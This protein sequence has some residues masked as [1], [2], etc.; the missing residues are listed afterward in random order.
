MNINRGSDFAIRLLAHLAA[1]GKETTSAA[2]AKKVDV[3]LNHLAKLV[4]VLSRGGFVSTR[5]GKGGG[6]KL[7]RD[8]RK[9]NLAE[10]IEAVEGPMGL[11]DCLFDRKAC[12]FSGKC[13]VRKYLGKVRSTIYH[14]LSAKTIAD[15]I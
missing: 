9:I 8:P 3:P 1:E 11:S 2:A 12:R 5:K 13:K 4:Q 15:I 14:M 10:V 7:A 6:L